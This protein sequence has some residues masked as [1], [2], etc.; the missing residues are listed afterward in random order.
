MLSKVSSP[1]PPPSKV[2][3]GGV[4]ECGVIAPLKT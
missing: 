3:E 1:P 4:R 2:T